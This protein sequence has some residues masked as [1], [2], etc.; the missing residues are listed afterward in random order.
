MVA[1]KQGGKPKSKPPGH[2]S[3]YNV[4]VKAQLAKLKDE[5]PDMDHRER[6]KLAALAW[7]KSP[8]NPKNRAT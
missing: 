6:F 5:H 8:R 7:A 3:Y 4:F 2:L 1:K